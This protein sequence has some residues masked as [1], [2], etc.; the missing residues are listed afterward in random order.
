MANNTN[1]TF[2]MTKIP[3]GVRIFHL[4]SSGQ[5]S[6]PGCSMKRFLHSSTDETVISMSGC[7][8]SLCWSYMSTTQRLLYFN[9]LYQPRTY[10]CISF[11]VCRVL[12]SIAPN[13]GCHQCWQTS[14]SVVGTEVQTR[15]KFMPSSCGHSLCWFIAVSNA[16]FYC[17]ALFLVAPYN[18][19]LAS[20]WMFVALIIVSIVISTLSYAKMF[21]TL[22]HQQAQVQNHV[23]RRVKRIAFVV[24]EKL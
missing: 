16:S 15:C 2:V 10:I 20:W 23:Q 5:Y 3:P 17:V 13:F 12:C 11:F 7:Y 14:R 6:H 8:W 22:R 9:S 18:V 19:L 1:G 4:C 24:F 21:F